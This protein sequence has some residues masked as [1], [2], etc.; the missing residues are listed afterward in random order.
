M[1]KKILIV[2][3]VLMIVI[4]LG[5]YY[6][7]SNLDS[8]VQGIIEESGSRVLQTE[9]KVE[10]VSVDLGEGRATINHLQVANPPGYSNNPAF[11]F[12]EVTAVVDLNSGVVKRIYTS[13]PEIRVEFKGEKSNFDVL[14]R[15]L[16]ESMAKATP[17]EEEA[18]KKESEQVAE[19]R[20]DE[21]VIEEAKATVTV[22]SSAE[23]L[24]VSMQRLEFD[25]LQGTPDH[26]ARTALSQFIAQVLAAVTRSMIEQKADE[27]IQEQGDKL[28]KKLK[29]L[30]E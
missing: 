18:Q 24:E 12:T 28:K 2:L 27:I 14:Q 1:L 3:I 25:N 19:I 29:S 9:V 11:R 17:G 16:E 20:I 6:V 5:A 8:I 4:G 23:P 26:V 10:S 22:D 15:N 30:L 21:V 13:Q 7:L